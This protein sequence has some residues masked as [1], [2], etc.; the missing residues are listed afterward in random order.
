MYLKNNCKNIY[1]SFLVD[2]LN[3]DDWSFGQKLSCHQKMMMHIAMTF[4]NKNSKNK[5]SNF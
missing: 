5:F 4:A 3:Y 2:I 1:K